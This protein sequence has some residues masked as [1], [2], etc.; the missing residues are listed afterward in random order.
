MKTQNNYGNSDRSSE[1]N[2]KKKGK[3]TMEQES[4]SDDTN[5][6]KNSVL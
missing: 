4:D 1:I 6:P 3:K 2:A 5:F